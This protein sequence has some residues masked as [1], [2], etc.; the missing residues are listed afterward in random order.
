MP[1]KSPKQLNR[2]QYASNSTL[3]F[4]EE[5]KGVVTNGLLA[6]FLS[7]LVLMMTSAVLPQAFKLPGDPVSGLI[8][9]AQVNVVPALCL[10]IAIRMVSQMRFFSK[11]DIQGAAY[12]QPSRLMAPRIAFLQNTMEQAA[13]LAIANFAV[14]TLGNKYV[15]G[16]MIGSAILFGIGRVLFW[17][18]YEAGARAR[19][20]GMVMTMAPAIGA[21]GLYVFAMGWRVVDAAV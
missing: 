11:A 9:A 17:I 7:A 13:L 18:S 10:L 16:Y 12:S 4:E 8:L 5:Q 21:L 1:D 14:S 3:A 20:F 2:K 6:M 15:M 19:A